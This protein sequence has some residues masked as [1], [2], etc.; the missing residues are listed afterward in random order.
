MNYAADLRTTRHFN[1]SL[2][3]PP[4]PGDSTWLPVG[5]PGGWQG[6]ILECYR[7]QVPVSRFRSCT[8]LRYQRTLEPARN[9]I[10][11]MGGVVLRN[12]FPNVQ[13]SGTTAYNGPVPERLSPG[14]IC[15]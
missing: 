10:S 12:S 14:A 9:R 8:W 5:L 4:T 2:D 1:P 3:Q 11:D 7:S 6:P 13:K 15:A